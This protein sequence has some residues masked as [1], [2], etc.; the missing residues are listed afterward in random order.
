[1]LQIFFCFRIVDFLKQ[2]YCDKRSG[3]EGGEGEGER[4]G[5]GESNKILQIQ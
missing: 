4:G 5:E 2:I 1:M 3:E